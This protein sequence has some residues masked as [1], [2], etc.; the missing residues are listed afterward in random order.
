MRRFRT[1]TLEQP[2]LVPPSLQ[3]WLPES[4]LARFIAEVVEQ[5]NL[6]GIL[7]TYAR[8]DDRGR[9]GYHPEML[10]RL[11]LYGYAIGLTSSRRIEKATYDNVAF[12][13][14]AADQHPDHDTIANF[15]QQHLEEL[16][17]LFVE[18][19]Q[20]CRQAGL[21]KLGN[22]AID[23]TKVKANAG[24]QHGHSYRQ[25]SEQERRLKKVAQRPPSFAHLIDKQLIRWDD[26]LH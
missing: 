4:H 23:G 2:L 6:D 7:S 14:L 17:V 10:V 19:L 21:V 24:R 18:A 5:L 26:A 1:C 13:Y 15:R 22:V 8:K 11:L 3:D 20:L 9:Q 16:A 25:L 12:R